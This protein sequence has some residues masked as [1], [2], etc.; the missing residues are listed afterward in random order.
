MKFRFLENEAT[1]DVA[2]EAYG[3]NLEETFE[4]S[5]IALF[6]IM[7]DTNKVKPLLNKELKLKAHDLKSLLYDFLERLLLFQDTENLLFSKFNVKKIEKIKDSYFLEAELK[8]DKLK[9]SHEKRNMVK[10][11]TYF[12]MEIEDNR[13]KVTVDI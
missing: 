3:K 1:A 8:G 7:T 2:F 5:A 9:K 6:E 10:A 13:A 12:G 11:V 4:N